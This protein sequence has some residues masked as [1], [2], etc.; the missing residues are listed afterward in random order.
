MGSG[1]LPTPN[2]HIQLYI[3]YQCST[4]PQILAEINIMED[5]IFENETPP[6]TQS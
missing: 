5:I 3:R 4:T 2:A 1:Q 6:I